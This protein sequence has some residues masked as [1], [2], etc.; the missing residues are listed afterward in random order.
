M[1][2]MQHVPYPHFAEYSLGV[3]EGMGI[4]AHIIFDDEFDKDDFVNEDKIERS[5]TM[6]NK[7]PR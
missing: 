3:M 6:D 2:P 1:D 4:V 7:G 5:M